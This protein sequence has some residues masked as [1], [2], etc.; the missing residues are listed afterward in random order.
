MT[1]S[2]IHG[3]AGI[4]SFV[5][6]KRKKKGIVSPGLKTR[7]EESE[8][9]VAPGRGRHEAMQP[10]YMSNAIPSSRCRRHIRFPICV[11]TH[12]RNASVKM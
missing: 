8:K 7:K 2:F 6:L 10:E 12:T 4:R 3:C 9:R 5:R 1:Q 11:I